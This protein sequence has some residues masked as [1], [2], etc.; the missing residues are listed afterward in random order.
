[1][2]PHSFRAEPGGG[3]EERREDLPVHAPQAA[4]DLV[5]PA[6]GELAPAQRW[7]PGGGDL[8]SLPAH[9]PD[10]CE[11]FQAAAAP[12]RG[13]HIFRT[14]LVLVSVCLQP[15]QDLVQNLDPVLLRSPLNHLL[16]PGG[17]TG[18]DEG[19]GGWRWEVAIP[20]ISLCPCRHNLRFWNAAFFDAVHCERRK[21]S[22]TTR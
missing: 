16:A 11:V 14:S 7:P 2:S 3:G 15:H 12:R 19:V 17:Q 18:E 10:I 6:W 8:S 21:R 5:K 1:M 20:N 22:P 9:S 4:A 13:G